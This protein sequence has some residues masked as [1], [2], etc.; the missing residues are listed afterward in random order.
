MPLIF[1]KKVND[2]YKQIPLNKTTYILGPNKHFP[3]STKEWLNSIYTYNNNSVK[4]LSVAD[5]NLT[6]LVKSYFYMYYGNKI[7]KFKRIPSWIRRRNLNQIFIGKPEL[8]HTNNKVVIT[9]YV[10]NQQKRLLDKKIKSF[11]LFNFP[12]KQIS[13]KFSS[14]YKRRYLINYLKDS[15]TGLNTLENR[16]NYFIDTISLE[17][18]EL[19]N[20]NKV[21]VKAYNKKVKLIKTLQLGLESTIYLINAC[22][23]NVKIQNICNLEAQTHIRDSIIGRDI[24]TISKLK[25]LLDLNTSKFH[26]NSITKLKY[27]VKKIY[28]KDVEFNIISLKN[29]YLDSNILTQTMAIKLKNRDN[30]LLRVLKTCISM[31][32]L[33]RVNRIRE[34]LGKGKPNILGNKL[35]NMFASNVNNSILNGDYITQMLQ[36]LFPNFIKPSITPNPIKSLGNDSFNKKEN[37]K[38]SIWLSTDDTNKKSNENLTIQN[39]VLNSL[40]DKTMAGVRLEARG[41]LT[42]RFTASRSLFKL[43]W[44]GSLQTINSSYKGLPSVMLRGHVKP[45]VQYSFTKNKTRNGA[46]GL[47]GWISSK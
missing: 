31:V 38:P 23:N 21:N 27:L 37:T 46:F 39:F 41:R 8:K 36:G 47:K 2:N 45:N 30:R 19:S 40:K 15:V 29:M 44:K 35:K 4:N 5:K 28:N 9:L 25:M 18:Q 24:L 14:I 42:R 34:R 33:P 7:L 10:F 12:T 11:N 6:S 32:K 1:T 43:K 26:D 17:K 16:L 20:M 3:S 13:D 22:K